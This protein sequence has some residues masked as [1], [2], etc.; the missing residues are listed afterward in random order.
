LL[1]KCKLKIFGKFWNLFSQALAAGFSS[2]FLH[3]IEGSEVKLQYPVG[4]F[5]LNMGWD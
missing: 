4:I 2:C 1:R 3:A 5:P